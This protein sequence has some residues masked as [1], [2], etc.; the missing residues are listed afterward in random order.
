[1][2]KF[3]NTTG[4]ND[5]RQR[6]IILAAIRG[7]QNGDVTARL[8]KEAMTRASKLDPRIPDPNNYLHFELFDPPNEAS[9]LP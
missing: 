8:L 5:I 4:V 6:P 1:M 3:R 7:Q 2:G 9:V